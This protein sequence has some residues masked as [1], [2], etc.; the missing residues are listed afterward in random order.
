M[1]FIIG[2]D[3]KGNAVMSR[4][5]MSAFVGVALTQATGAMAADVPNILPPPAE[6]WQAPPLIDP[7]S[8]WYLRGEVGYNWGRL[9]G[10]E[11]AFGYTDP[12]DS[13]L[14]DGVMFGVGAG[15]KSQWLRTDF[16]VDYSLPL[17]YQG[18]IATLGD[19]T[20]KISAVSGLFNGYIDLGTWYN[21]TPYI[22]AGTGAAYLRAFDYTS[23]LAPPFSGD[24]THTQWNFS[25][26]VMA[27]F[28][29]VVT[30]HLMVDLGYRYIDFGDVQTANDSFG[31]MTFQNVAAHEVRLG[32]RWSFDD[33]HPAQ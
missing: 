11:S 33:L 3:R 14:G 6:E 24:T 15:F 16:T 28:G 12:T 23:T 30:P 25:W 29:Y 5:R 1:D 7:N 32:L 13:S 2:G 17:K 26:A 8:G 22:G 19:V 20:A 21:I 4:L 18:T 9:D 27:G 31:S 10:A